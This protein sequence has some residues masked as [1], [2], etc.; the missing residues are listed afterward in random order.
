MA[1]VAGGRKLRT[2][3]NKKWRSIERLDAP[4]ICKFNVNVNVNVNV[5][6]EETSTQYID[7]EETSSHCTV[8]QNV[9]VILFERFVLQV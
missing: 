3:R 6:I 5:N 1:Q 2:G 8:L 4:S 7:I 9:T